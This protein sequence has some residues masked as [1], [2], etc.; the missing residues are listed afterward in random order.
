MLGR[1]TA[2]VDR[3]VYVNREED[4]GGN[5]EQPV[6]DAYGPNFERLAAVNISATSSGQ[7][8]N[9]RFSSETSRYDRVYKALRWTWHD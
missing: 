9:R 8:Q 7:S 2:F 5:S 3:A 1:H 4:A 6:R